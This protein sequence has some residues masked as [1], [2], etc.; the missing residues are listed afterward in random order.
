MGASPCVAAKP[1][2]LVID[3]GL[4]DNKYNTGYKRIAVQYLSGRTRLEADA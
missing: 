2:G 1:A 4:A 3:C